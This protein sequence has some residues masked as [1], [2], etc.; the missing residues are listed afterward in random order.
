[1]QSFIFSSVKHFRYER[2]F[3]IEH[4]SLQE[5]E[6]LLRLHPALFSEI[7]RQRFVNN[8]Y[9]DSLDA[10]HYFDNINGFNR[11]LKIRVRWY[12][13]L[14]GNI[15]SPVLELKLK[16]NLHVGKII[17]PLQGFRLDEEF[18]I[19]QLRSVFEGSGLPPL[20][21]LYLRTL[22]FSLLNRYSR[23]YF[24]SAD[25]NYRATMDAGMQAYKLYSFSNTFLQMHRDERN[26]ILELKYNNPHDEGVDKITNC[27]PFR[28]TRSSKYV[29]GLERLNL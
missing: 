27:F 28:M 9:L 8:L 12:G 20:L 2:K 22:G 19:E 1:M 5:L 4:L 25:R 15:Q 23:K 11:R 26:A 18:S 3:F 6:L 29:Y 13:D 24:L 10:R 14:F 21:L 7:Y 16:H 17:Y